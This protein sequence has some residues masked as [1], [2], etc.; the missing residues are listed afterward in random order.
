[1]K[2]GCAKPVGI[3][4]KHIFFEIGVDHAN[5]A[6]RRM[7]HMI[8]DWTSPGAGATLDTCSDWFSMFGI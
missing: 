1:V 6:P 8:H 5:Q 3:A 4:G 2:T 7:I